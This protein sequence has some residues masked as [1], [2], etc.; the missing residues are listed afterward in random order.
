MDQGHGAELNGKLRYAG[1]QENFLSMHMTG[2]SLLGFGF[3]QQRRVQEV[4]G[5]GTKKVRPEK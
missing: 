1:V 3:M 4:V 2:K 5:G